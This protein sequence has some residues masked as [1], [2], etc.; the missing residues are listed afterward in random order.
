MAYRCHGGDVP[1]TVIRVKAV[2]SLGVLTTNN[3]NRGKK[4]SSS[5]GMARGWWYSTE[6]LD[7]RNY[8]IS[9]QIHLLVVFLLIYTTSSPVS[10]FSYSSL[11]GNFAS[12]QVRHGWS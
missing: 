2:K 1:V 5:M 12:R 3:W 7:D 8:R 10:I 11:F 9:R 4:N 6:I